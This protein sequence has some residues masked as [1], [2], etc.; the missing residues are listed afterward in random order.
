M[1][2]RAMAWGR[3]P[4]MGR[5]SK[6]TVPRLGGST[7]ITVRMVVV[8]PAPLRP[9]STVTASGRTRSETPCRMWCWPMFVCTPSSSS[10]SGMRAP[11]VR[12]LDLRARADLGGRPVGDEAAV[13]QHRDRVGQGHHHVDLV[14]D[15]QDGA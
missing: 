15:E 9:S 11:E 10:T 5:P 4:W 2:S 1:P 6:R 7:P 13:L 8:L 3:R 14:L 12:G